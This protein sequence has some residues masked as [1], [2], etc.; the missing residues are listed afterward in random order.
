MNSST[1]K[2][3]GSPDGLPRKT[4]ALVLGKGEDG[5]YQGAAGDTRHGCGKGLKSLRGF[6]ADPLGCGGAH[7]TDVGQNNRLWSG[8]R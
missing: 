8:A 7:R 3:A 4:V 6:G 5:R 1:V 2:A